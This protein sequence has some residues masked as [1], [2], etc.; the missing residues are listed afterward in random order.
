MNWRTAANDAFMM[1]ILSDYVDS[2][3]KDLQEESKI[4]TVETVYGVPEGATKLGIVLQFKRALNDEVFNPGS[5]VLSM[6]RA[7]PKS[8]GA[9][10][11]RFFVGSPRGATVV[12][13]D[14]TTTG[15][16]LLNCIDS[17]L[18]SE[19]EVVAAIGLTNRMEVSDQG[20]SVADKVAGKSYRGSSIPYFQM[21]NAL[22]LLP[23]AVKQHSPSTE[24]LTRIEAELEQIRGDA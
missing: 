9:P 11:D 13:E 1:N 6:G 5:H 18:E 10:Q 3:I 17:L 24:V 14:V 15:G 20:L 23:L 7:A 4:P 16:S 21:S 2:F 8:H 22:D 12:I 19:V